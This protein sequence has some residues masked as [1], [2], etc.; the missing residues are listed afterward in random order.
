[1][2]G[3]LTYVDAGGTQYSLS[4][5]GRVLRAVRGFGI[6]A[7]VHQTVRT[8][9][10]DGET[11]IRSLYEPRFVIADV[12]L[13]DTSWSAIQA[14]RVSLAAALNPRA[15]IGELRWQPVP[16]GTTYALPAVL[17]SFGRDSIGSR[18]D[19]MSLAFRCPDPAIRVLPINSDQYEALGSGSDFPT[20]FP[21]DFLAGTPEVINNAGH[22][23]SPPVIVVTGQVT[24]PF[25]LNQTTGQIFELDVTIPAGMTA[26]IDMRG[27]TAVRSDGL[28]L[29][30]F[31]SAR[32]VMWS[33][34]P[35]NNTVE[36]GWEAAA[37]PPVI[38]DFAFWTLLAGV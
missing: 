19:R 10:R 16:A 5:S 11:L 20:D 21:T 26:T 4:S 31:R 32:S 28:N 37:S 14:D 27:R 3:T 35:G 18:L 34:E 23:A 25:I 9:G 24:G 8:P 7:V 13:I 17:E 33:L 1:M 15:G 38:F 12:T 22:L 30:P 2:T 6:P 29:M 36:F